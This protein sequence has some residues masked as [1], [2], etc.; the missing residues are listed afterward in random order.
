MMGRIKRGNIKGSRNSKGRPVVGGEGKKTSP[1]G[2]KGLRIGEVGLISN[3]KSQRRHHKAGG[4]RRV[5]GPPRGK[6]TNISNRLE[7]ELD[8]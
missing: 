3:G 2:G 4:G 8:V 6:I 7:K 5:M 1:L